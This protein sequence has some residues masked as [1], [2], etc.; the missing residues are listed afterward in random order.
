[1]W[2][3]YKS[4]SVCRPGGFSGRPRRFIAANMSPIQD[5]PLRYQLAN[6]LHAR[7]F[8]LQSAPGHVAFVAIKPH[9]AAASRDRADERAHLVELLNRYGAPHPQPGATHYSGKLGR[10]F[11]KWE[12]HTEFFT[13]TLL[14]EGSEGKPFDKAAFDGFPDDWLEDAPGQRVTSALIHIVRGIVPETIRADLG[15]WFEVESLAAVYL[16]DREALM[17][18]DFRIDPAG[19]MRF[20][21]FVSDTTGASRTGRVVQRICEIEIYKT[22]SMLGF[23]RA[24]QMAPRLGQLAEDLSAVVAG[25]NQP[26]SE[27]EKV[28][29]ELLTISAAL[30][31]LEAQSSFRFGATAAYEA[32]VNQRIEVLREERFEG[33]QTF[34]EFMMRRFDPAMRTVKST[35]ARLR[36]LSDRAARASE[37]LR[38]QVDVARS[39]QSQALLESMNR[40]ADLQLRLQQTVEGLSVVA[41]S[42]Y[43]VNLAG[44]MLYPLTEPA[45]FS[46]GTTLAAITPVVVVLVWYMVHRIR[47]GLGH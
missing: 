9:Q 43:A 30:E 13:Y 38:T 36:A 4:T 23:A 40:R 18:S 21:L 47:R 12:S 19:H 3:D 37:L 41:I 27:P 16:L 14:A 6:E 34:G 7:P 29:D 11:L 1:M 32:I 46:K 2:R 31:H 39:A 8:P 44:Y 35:E 28:L 24:G 25:L 10:Y 42:Y 33:R 26:G 17:A 45:G 22:M 5:H 20:A 15:K